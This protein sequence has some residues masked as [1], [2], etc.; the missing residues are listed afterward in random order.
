MPIVCPACGT[1]L[2]LQIAAVMSAPGMEPLRTTA[3]AETATAAETAAAEVATAAETAAA[4]TAPPA[5]RS[6]AVPKTT[7]G[8]RSPA[9][10][11]KMLRSTIPT[12]PKELPPNSEAKEEEEEAKEEEQ[13]EN[14]FKKARTT[15]LTMKAEPSAFATA[16]KVPTA[17][18]PFAAVPVPHAPDTSA[19][20][21]RRSA[22]VERPPSPAPLPPLPS[23]T[24]W[25]VPPPPPPPP[26]ASARPPAPAFVLLQPGHHVAHGVVMPANVRAIPPET[27]P[28]RAEVAHRRAAEAADAA[29]RQAVAEQQEAEAAAAAEAAEEGEAAEAARAHGAGDVPAEAEAAE[30]AEAQDGQVTNQVWNKLM[31]IAW[32]KVTQKDC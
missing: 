28:Q 1:T 3:A 30:A 9:G 21:K 8:S 23:E 20:P 15:T 14:P 18:S 4:E 27:P 6:P 11:Q 7:L 25:P 17:S 13:T 5:P 32:A 10:P 22:A 31:K 12:T 24:S 16:P 29:W 26:P 2:Q 19:A